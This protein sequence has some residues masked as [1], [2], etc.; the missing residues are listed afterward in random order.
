M[1][2]RVPGL[3]EAIMSDVDCIVD[4]WVSI[5]CTVCMGL[6]KLFLRGSTRAQDRSTHPHTHAHNH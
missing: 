1:Q 6:N 3:R 2:L 4:S 5:L